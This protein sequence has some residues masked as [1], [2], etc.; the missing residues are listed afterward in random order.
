MQSALKCSYVLISAYNLLAFPACS[1]SLTISTPNIHFWLIIVFFCFY[2]SFPWSCIYQ[3]IH[4]VGEEAQNLSQPSFKVWYQK[5]P[6]YQRC[7]YLENPTQ[8]S[9]SGLE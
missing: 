8:A 9:G 7:N 5:D 2:A 3:H 4:Q 6:V 1:P